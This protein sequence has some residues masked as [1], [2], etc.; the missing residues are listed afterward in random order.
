MAVSIGAP[1][2]W[3]IQRW[4]VF[5]YTNGAWQLVLDKPAF[6][7]ELKGVGNNIRERTPV[8]RSGDN[9]C[10]PTGGSHARL[11]HWNGS[12]LVAGPWKQVTPGQKA[13]GHGRA[14]Y[15]KTPSGNIQC[16]WTTF[17]R[18][19]VVSCA[20][21]S[22]IKPPPPR[23]GPHCTRAFWVSVHPSG[24]PSWA[25]SICP[26]EDA[27][28]SPLVGQT[29]TVVRY[30][31]GWSLRGITCSS[32]FKGLTCRNKSGHGFFMSRADTHLI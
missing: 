29:H 19:P 30:G 14:G 8:F 6:V 28:E 13:P 22:G 9:R 20:I 15:F 7:F 24:R 26:G 12:K 21:K 10:N 1:T 2:C 18:S 16:V 25:G 11:W 23:R 31:K 5:S 17:G 27:P 4:A 3:G 32:A